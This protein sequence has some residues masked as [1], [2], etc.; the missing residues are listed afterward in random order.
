MQFVSMFAVLQ[1]ALVGELEIT[2]FILPDFTS[3]P[4]CLPVS[5]QSNKHAGARATHNETPDECSRQQGRA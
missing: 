3:F 4:E 1:D 5:E 2:C